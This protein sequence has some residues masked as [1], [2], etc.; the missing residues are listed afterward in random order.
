MC[1]TRPRDVTT[2]TDKDTIHIFTM[3]CHVIL[4][5]KN[6]QMVTDILSMIFNRNTRDMVTLCERIIF[7]KKLY[8]LIS[9]SEI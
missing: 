2:N 9:V 6:T 5:I 7:I 8:E 3:K 4:Y 1:T